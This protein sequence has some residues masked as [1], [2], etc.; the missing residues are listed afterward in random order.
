MGFQDSSIGAGDPRR[1]ARRVAAGALAAA[2]L[3]GAGPLA[4]QPRTDPATQSSSRQGVTVKVTPRIPDD[5]SGKW[6]FAVVLDT[7]TRELGDDLVGSATLV[8]DDGRRLK[9]TAWTGAGPGGHHR[10]GVLGFSVHPP[11]PRSFELVIARPGE[12][13]PRVFRWK[14]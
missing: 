2:L 7:H 6:E 4:A 8:T 5:G 1:N 11:L 9:P 3:V 14:Q 13:T 12:S 10:E